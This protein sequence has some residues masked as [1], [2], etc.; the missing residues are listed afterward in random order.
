MNFVEKLQKNYDPNPAKTQRDTLINGIIDSIVA[1][2]F[3]EC[4]KVSKTQRSLSGYYGSDSWEG[5]H[6]DENIIMANRYVYDDVNWGNQ[7]GVKFFNQ[8]RLP[9]TFGRDVPNIIVNEVISKLQDSGFQNPIVR[10]ENTTK[11]FRYGTS[12]IL[13]KNKYMNAPCFVFYISVHW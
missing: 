5:G 3:K 6:I 12:S 8:G 7:E 10:F 2:V 1:A 13:L 9:E 11:Q 4:D